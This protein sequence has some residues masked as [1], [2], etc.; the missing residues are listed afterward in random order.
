MVSVRYEHKWGITMLLPVF[1]AAIFA[2]VFV[3][4]WVVSKVK[5]QRV[6]MSLKNR[7]VNGKR[8]GESSECSWL[9]VH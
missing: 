4:A 1:F 5:R 2:L 3:G 8:N 7:I 6:S 9:V